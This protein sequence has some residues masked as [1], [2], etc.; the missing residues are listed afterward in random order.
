MNDQLLDFVVNNFNFF[1]R[2]AI[3]YLLAS[4]KYC[5]NSINA[6][7]NF[8]LNNMWDTEKIFRYSYLWRELMLLYFSVVIIKSKCTH[9][10]CI[11]LSCV[12]CFF[13]MGFHITTKIWSQVT[14]TYTQL[15][16]KLSY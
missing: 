16:E 3:I 8:R 4:S 9:F 15:D 7:S 12:V 14:M 13:L 10:T 5:T 2:K 11:A 1:S 6:S